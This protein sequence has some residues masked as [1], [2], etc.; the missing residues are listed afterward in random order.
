MISNDDYERKVFVLPIYSS[1]STLNHLTWSIEIKTLVR[2]FTSGLSDN[3]YRRLISYILSLSEEEV[4]VFL[5]ESRSFY[6]PTFYNPKKSF[7]LLKALVDI[8]DNR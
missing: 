4:Y 7:K 3:D 5:L 1:L 6:N 2:F 8:I